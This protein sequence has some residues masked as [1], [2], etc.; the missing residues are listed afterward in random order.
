MDTGRPIWRSR[1]WLAT[2]LTLLIFGLVISGIGIDSPTTAAV[3][4]A[5]T[6]LV[7]VAV[8]V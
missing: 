7:A 6:I 2:L 5:L 3:V 8:I 1:V 4:L